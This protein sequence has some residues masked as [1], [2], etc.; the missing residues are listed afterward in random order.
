M[1]ISV[2]ICACVDRGF[3]SRLLGRQPGP[4]AAVELLA[5][6]KTRNWVERNSEDDYQE[7]L[8]REYTAYWEARA[9]ARRQGEKR[10]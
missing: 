3:F 6:V 2:N 1:S 7:A 9:G 8:L 5:M 10:T 4:E